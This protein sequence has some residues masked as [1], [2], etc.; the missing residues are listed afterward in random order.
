MSDR[1]ADITRAEAMLAGQ[2][3]M[4]S[5]ISLTDTDGNGMLQVKAGFDMGLTSTVIHFKNGTKLPMTIAE[6]PA[7]ALWF[8]TA[9]NSFFV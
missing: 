8:V 4:G 9:R 1:E 5:M 3:Y 2:D 6:F 7:F